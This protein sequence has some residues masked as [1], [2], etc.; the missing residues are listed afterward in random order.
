M[1]KR[2]EENRREGKGKICTQNKP[3][4]IFTKPNTTIRLFAS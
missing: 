3:K 2:R 4:R 1:K